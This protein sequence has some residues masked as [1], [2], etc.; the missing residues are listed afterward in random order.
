MAI[1]PIVACAH[2]AAN[3]LSGLNLSSR[4]VPNTLFYVELHI[5]AFQMEV[6]ITMVCTSWIDAVL[7]GDDLPNFRAD[8]I[9]TLATFG[10]NELTYCFN[11]NP[12]FLLKI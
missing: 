3:K 7:N 5:A 12:F 1:R 8:L 10:V 2:L 6:G 4:H 11:H 9:A